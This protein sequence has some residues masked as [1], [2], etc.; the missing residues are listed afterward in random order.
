MHI[1]IYRERE[2]YTNTYYITHQ[3]GAQGGG[4]ALPAEGV[5]E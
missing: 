3:A 4:A 1:Y 2:I 5:P